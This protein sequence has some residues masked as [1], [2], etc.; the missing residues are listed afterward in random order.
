[1]KKF[2]FIIDLI[3][4]MDRLMKGLCVEGS[5]FIDANTHRLTFRP[6]HR[7]SRMP[8]YQPPA[9]E[10]IR[11]T[12]YGVVT[13]S[14]QRIRLRESIPSKLGLARVLSIIDREIKEVKSALVEREIIDR[15]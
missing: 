5:I 7:Q 2:I 13:K 6:Y 9:E 3:E 4:V 15:V 1:M 8:G 12:E 11:Q 14:A 10:V